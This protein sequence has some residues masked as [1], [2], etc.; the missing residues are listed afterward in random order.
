VVEKSLFGGRGVD[1]D[2]FAACRGAYQAF[3]LPART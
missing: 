3:A 2:E 1:A